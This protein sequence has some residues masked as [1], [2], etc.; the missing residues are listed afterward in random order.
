[1]FTFTDLQSLLA[2]RPFTPFRLHLSDGTPVPVISPEVV[3]VGRRF[4]LVGLLEAD[5][6]DKLVDRWTVVYY[7]HVTRAEMLQSGEP[8]FSPGSP[9]ASPGSPSPASR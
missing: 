1:M 9:P 7:M 8:P 6:T 4:A 3:V 2:A 5:A